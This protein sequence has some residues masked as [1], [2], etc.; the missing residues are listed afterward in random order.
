MWRP[1]TLSRNMQ[2]LRFNAGPYVQNAFASS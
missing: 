2:E 1:Y